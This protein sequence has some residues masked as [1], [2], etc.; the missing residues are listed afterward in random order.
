M[1][2]RDTP[3]MADLA[4]TMD[5]DPTLEREEFGGGSVSPESVP[6]SEASSRGSLLGTRLSSA[7]AASYLSRRTFCGTMHFM[8]PEVLEESDG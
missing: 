6:S 5:R 8:A 1:L 2:E 4:P 3:F 7:S